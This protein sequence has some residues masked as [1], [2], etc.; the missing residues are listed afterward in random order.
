MV[1][2]PGHRKWASVRRPKRA[3]LATG[4]HVLDVA[5][6]TG[7]LAREASFLVG[8]TG[9]VIGLDPGPRV[10]SPRPDVRCRSGLSVLALKSCRWHRRAPI[11]SRWATRSGTYRTLLRCSA[12]F[13]ACSSRAAPSACW[14]SPSRAVGSAAS[15]FRCTCGR[16]CQWRA[17]SREDREENLRDC[18][19]STTANNLRMWG[20]AM[21]FGR[22][23]CGRV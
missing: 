6:G 15:C 22:L 8:H 11:T 5:V 9:S 7:L 2:R 19:G 18:C 21:H 1:D 23:G 3:G 4:S 20:A 14:K 16:W 13:T 12:S 10:C 17:G